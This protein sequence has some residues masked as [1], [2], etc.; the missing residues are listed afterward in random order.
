MNKKILCLSH[1]DFIQ[2]SAILHLASLEEMIAQ[3][4]LKK[5]TVATDAIKDRN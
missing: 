2:H 1:L 3:P 4:L 5:T